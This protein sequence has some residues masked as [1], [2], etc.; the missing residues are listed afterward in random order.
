MHA[1][2]SLALAHRAHA[3]LPDGS[4]CP[5]GIGLYSGQLRLS[6]RAS[7]RTIRN[8]D[9]PAGYQLCM[10]FIDNDAGPPFRRQARTGLLRAG[11]DPFPA[12]PR[13]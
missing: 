10:Q 7:P 6:Q 5:R 12:F 9:L 2:H 1:T 3:T 4:P 13:R 8:G 11:R